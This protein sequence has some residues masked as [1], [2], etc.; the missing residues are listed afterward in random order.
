M[1][2]T[3]MV[4]IKI[5]FVAVR[6]YQRLIRLKKRKEKKRKKPIGKFENDH[7]MN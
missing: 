2:E 5:P 1:N 7:L 6:I 4:L 3:F